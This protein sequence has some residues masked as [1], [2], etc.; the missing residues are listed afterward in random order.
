[1]QYGIDH[2]DEAREKYTEI[3]QQSEAVQV[4]EQGVWVNP[5]YPGLSCSPDGIVGSPELQEKILLKIKVIC[6]ENVNPKQFEKFMTKEQQQAF[7]LKR[8]DCGHIFLRKSHKYYRQIQHSLCVLELETAHL[9]VWGKG[10]TLI[11]EVKRD[12]DYFE[13]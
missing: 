4:E 11:R 5:K 10:G 6:A 1:M 2:E 8:D 9:F 3:M 7:Y 12:E 13:P